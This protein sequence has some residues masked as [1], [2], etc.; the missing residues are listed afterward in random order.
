M[1][2]NN[3]HGSPYD[4]GSADRYY[5]REWQPHYFKGNTYRSEKVDRVDMTQ[6]EIDQYTRGYEEQEDFKDW[7]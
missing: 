3:R 7:G 4:R 6:E 5:R 1:V 2:D